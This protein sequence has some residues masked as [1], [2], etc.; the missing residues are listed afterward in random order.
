[1][2]TATSQAITDGLTSEEDW[3]RGC[4]RLLK[5]AR[6]LGDVWVGQLPVGDARRRDLASVRHWL[7]ERLLAGDSFP[8]TMTTARALL[9]TECRRLKAAPGYCRGR[10]LDR[11]PLLLEAG[12]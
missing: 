10:P 7:D 2:Q 6:R 5:A 1:M 4:E 12:S 3:A 9:C 11:C 8:D